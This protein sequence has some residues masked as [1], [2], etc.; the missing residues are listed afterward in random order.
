MYDMLCVT[1]SWEITFFKR[2]LLS[3]GRCGALKPG[4]AY[5]LPA[6]GQGSAGPEIWWDDTEP[7]FLHS[8]S[9]HHLEKPPKHHHELSKSRRYD[10]TFRRWW[11]M[12][13]LLPLRSSNAGIIRPTVETR[14][15][16]SV[17][18]NR[19]WFDFSCVFLVPCHLL[20]SPLDCSPTLWEPARWL[21]QELRRRKVC[22]LPG[23]RWTWATCTRWGH[24]SLA[25]SFS[26]LRTCS[27]SSVGTW[28]EIYPAACFLSDL[29]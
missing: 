17:K 3:T 18:K 25:N 7:G 4:C 15:S 22:P 11:E 10:A 12:A 2:V 29:W 1:K 19:V 5:C 14:M 28:A 27:W 6:L 24:T 26:L 9:W 23:R 16:Y 21:V 13:A 8:P 20:E